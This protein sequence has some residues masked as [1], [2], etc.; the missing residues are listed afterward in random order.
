[1]SLLEDIQTYSQIFG[2]S[3]AEDQVIRHFV[4]ELRELG[5]TPRVD[6]LGNVTVPIQPPAPGWPHVLVCAHLDEVGFV[7]RKIESSGLL[8]VT[9]I[10]GINDRAIAGQRVVFQTADGALVEGCVGLKAKHLSTPEEIR[11]AI[12]VDEAYIDVMAAS[13][14]EVR[15]MGLEVGDPGTFVGPFIHRGSW[16][17]GKALDNRVGIALL[18]ELARR[19]LQQPLR[20]G[21]TLLAT[22]QEEFTMRGGTPAF[23]AIQPD[24]AIGLDVAVATDTPDSTSLS[25]IDLGQGV[26]IH[27]YSKGGPSGL[28]PNPKLVAYAR[29]VARDS[30]IPAVPGV[31]LG[32]LTDASFM[33]YEGAGVAFLELGFPTRYTHTPVETCHLGDIQ[34]T[35]DL[36]W[37]MLHKL[38]QGFELQRG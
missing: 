12:P 5:F 1:M 37:A 19:V 10:G 11:T 23:R 21:L 2:P 34:A 25:E 31:L 36:T 20:V 18:V 22:V 14:E 13:A 28:I 3:G 33:Q 6:A 38:P 4:A 15:A 27:R 29:N 16:I 7:V 30:G 24:F 8:R 17:R 9:R 35:A 32:G 26:V